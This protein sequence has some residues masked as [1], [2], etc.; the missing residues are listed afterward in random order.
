MIPALMLLPI[1]F[2]CPESPRFLIRNREYQKALRSLC[3]LRRTELQACR[4]LVQTHKQLQLSLKTN[5]GCLVE[6]E[7][8]EEA[9][10]LEMKKMHFPQRVR[11]LFTIPRNRKACLSAFVA[12]MA[13]QLCGVSQFLRDCHLC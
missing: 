11:Q 7:Y 6:D 3:A 10:Q 5:Y 8:G 2:I 12:M 9:Y 13:Q 4:D 1:L